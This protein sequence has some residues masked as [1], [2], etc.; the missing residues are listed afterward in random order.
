M[1]NL[2]LLFIAVVLVSGCSTQIRSA[3]SVGD[4]LASGQK[5]MIAIPADGRYENQIYSGSGTETA[6]RLRT[7]LSS[8]A[9]AVT[10]SS[11]SGGNVQAA[12]KEGANQGCRYVIHPEITHWEHRRAAWSG[13]PSKVSFHMTVYDL[14]ARNQAVLQRSLDA[15]GRIMT[16]VSQY[17]ADMAEVMFKDF[18]V[19]VF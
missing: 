8:K 2:A 3:G 18:V 12:L 15:R 16:F 11:S 17:P 1:K 19:E 13:R 14:Q 10:L 9:A 7:A 6:N 4:R 5:I